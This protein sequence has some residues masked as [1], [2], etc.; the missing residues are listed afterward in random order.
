MLIKNKIR[1]YSGDPAL[2]NLKPRVSTNLNGYSTMKRTPLEI[3]E[4]SKTKR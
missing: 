2:G 4:F 3:L 1:R